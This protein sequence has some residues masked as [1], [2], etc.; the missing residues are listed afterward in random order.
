MPI[1][2]W[3]RSI[4]PP[5]ATRRRSGGL[6]APCGT[7]TRSGTRLPGKYSRKRSRQI[8][9]AEL[10]T[11]AWR[12]D[13][14]TIR[15]TR[16]LRP[17]CPLGLAAIQAAKATGAKSQRER[18]YIDALAVMYIDYDKIPHGARVQS[19]LK[20]MEALAAK[21]PDDDE[22]QIFYAIT[23]NVAASP[24]DKTYSNQLKGAAILEAINKRQP[25]HP[26]VAHYLIDLY[27]SGAPRR[28]GS[29]TCPALLKDRAGCAACA[30]YALAHLHARRALER[31]YCG[32]Y[33]LRA[34]GQGRQVAR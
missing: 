21:Y 19:Y 5:R 10:P 33:C 17:T 29:T 4:S 11:G 12:S 32:E 8:R 18:D 27:D 26:G 14:S 13:Y 16:R 6:T 20:A 24:T 3:A 31:L 22:A 25:R 1:R 28:K 2:N 30:A 7:S 9:R 15:T 23:L 34:S